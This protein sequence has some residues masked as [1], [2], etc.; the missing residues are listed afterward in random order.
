MGQLLH[1]CSNWELLQGTPRVGAEVEGTGRRGK[2]KRN[3]K[4]KQSGKRKIRH[5]AEKPNRK[6]AGGANL[7]WGK[8]KAT[9]MEEEW[10][11]EDTEGRRNVNV[12]REQESKLAH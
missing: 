9:M 11:R 6:G 10:E 5:E 7:G 8:K 1:D 2:K 12:L 3:V 4:T